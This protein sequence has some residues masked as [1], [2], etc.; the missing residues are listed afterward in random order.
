ML[1]L[2]LHT[3]GRGLNG[4]TVSMERLRF[5]WSDGARTLRQGPVQSLVEFL[6][7]R[8]GRVNAG[9]ETRLVYTAAERA[10]VIF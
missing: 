5:L 6:K 9:F 1:S 2:S 4:L 3:L 7:R 10:G 8:N